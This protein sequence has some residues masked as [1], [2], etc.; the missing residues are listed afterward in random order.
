MPLKEQIE[1]DM[2]TAM[3]NKDKDR[4][5]ALRSIKS[6][7]LLE[8]TKEGSGE[9]LTQ[10]QELAL[11][12]KAAKQRRDSYEV[13]VQQNRA[14]L[15]EV[16]KKELEVIESYLPK[17]LS[18][19]ELRVEL[20]QIM[21]ETEAQ[22]PSDLGKVMGLASKKLAGRADNKRVAELVKNLLNKG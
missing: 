7:I 17:Q 18:D 10:A 1:A 8:A 11:L 19:T 9:H 16:E 5:T 20:E 4:L 14:D 2:K 13:Y 21:K 3:R 15:A 6:M 22:G 12:T